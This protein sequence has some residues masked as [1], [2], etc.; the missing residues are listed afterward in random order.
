MIMKKFI[1]LIL[2]LSLSQIAYSQINK[3]L[4]KA[5]YLFEQQEF[6]NAATLY[7]QVFDKIKSNVEKANVAEKIGDCYYS[8][9]NYQNSMKWYNT[10]YTLDTNNT[11]YKVKYAE[12]LYANGE[13]NK[14]FELFKSLSNTP[15]LSF[16][17]RMKLDGLRYAFDQL[18]IP[19]LYDIININELNTPYSEYYPFVYK[20]YLIFSSSRFMTSN[21]EV[22]SY[23]GQAFSKIYISYY[24]SSLGKWTN[25]TPFNEK[26]NNKINNGVATYVPIENSL[27]FMR[28]NEPKGRGKFCNIFKADSVNFDKAIA[29]NIQKIELGNKNYNVG[30]A[31]FTS[32]GKTMYFVSDNPE[33]LGN[34]DIYV[35][36]LNAN[37]Q[38][39]IPRNL[40]KSINTPNNEMFPVVVGDT[41]LYFSSNGFGG[42]GGLDILSCKIKND[43]VISDP[44]LLPYPINS[45]GDDFGIIFLSEDRGIFTSNRSGGKGD[46]DFYYFSY[47]PVMLNARGKVIDKNTRM[48]LAQALITLSINDT[49]ID[50]TYTNNEGEYFLENI[51]NDK[52]YKIKAIKRDYIPQEKELN[53]FGEKRSRTLS[54]ET[55]HNIDFELF[56]VTKEE[57][58]INNIYYD[59][60]KWTLR[61][62]SYIELNKI[63]EILNENPQMII[64]INS[65]TDA[66]GSDE[67]NLSLSEKRAQSVV[68]YLI[69]KGISPSR[70]KY[71]GWGESNL[72][73]KDAQTEEEHQLNRRTTFNLL[74][75]DEWNQSFYDQI[76]TNVSQQYNEKTVFNHQIYIGSSLD[77]NIDSLISIISQYETN[78]KITKITEDGID[79]YYIGPFFLYDD[80]FTLWEKIRLIQPNAYIAI[81]KNSEPIGKIQLN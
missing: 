35:T 2:F 72:L 12:S 51:I 19:P 62:E 77:S 7:E 71:K 61:P 6:Y 79:R 28:C 43:V 29:K 36:T 9:A 80:A 48:P 50:T 74:N 16:M 53:T 52:K 15:N 81:F 78:L 33:G 8:F 21:D 44:I 37:G 20:N 59:F 26:I 66:R 22:Y 41:M 64:Q 57:I 32:D 56:K 45:S 24:D 42:M 18:S 17:V 70:L 75:V 5:N 10:A 49:I 39:N 55:G 40:G 11:N 68:N 23:N 34:K 76:Y 73:I 13:Y 69:S 4:E 54:S 65:H 46:D 67:Y 14:A 47:A 3:M 25:I 58:V 30:H 31:T 27:Y 63:V 60:D 38:W 1:V